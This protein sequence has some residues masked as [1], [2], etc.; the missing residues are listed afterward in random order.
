MSTLT[1][2]KQSS[3]QIDLFTP[4]THESV[5]SSTTASPLPSFDRFPEIV[6]AQAARIAGRINASGIS[7]VEHKALLAERQKLLDKQL[8]DE[9]TTKEANRLEYVRWSLD[10]IEDAKYG[11]ALD[12]LEGTV[13]R[14]ESLLSELRVLDERLRQFQP[15]VTKRK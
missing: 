6:H 7:E 11:F 10:R 14:Y 4:A 2:K 13:A 1:A 15:A 12:F 8:V 9:I 3:E 5:S